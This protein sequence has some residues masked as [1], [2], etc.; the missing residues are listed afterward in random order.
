MTSGD[1][2]ETLYLKVSEDLLNDMK[3][4]PTGHLNIYRK[5]KYK[6]PAN[7]KGKGKVL[8]K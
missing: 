5:R 1:C 3:K 8:S 6:K 7:M 4:L 2:S